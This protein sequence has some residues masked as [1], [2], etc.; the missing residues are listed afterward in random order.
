MLSKTDLVHDACAT[1]T[2]GLIY[3]QSKE[4][5]AASDVTVI[6]VCKFLLKAVKSFQAGEEPPHI[7]RGSANNTFR[8]LVT[9]SEKLPTK[10]S[11]EQRLAQCMTE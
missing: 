5:L 3:D 6:A 10:I 4:H 8:H 7:V 2:M 1:E 11:P 9:I